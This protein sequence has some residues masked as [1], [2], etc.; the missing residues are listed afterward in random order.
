M[1]NVRTM[2]AWEISR[3]VERFVRSHGG[4]QYL[5]HQRVV[6]PLPE[7]TGVETCAEVIERLRRKGLDL[8][9]DHEGDRPH[10]FMN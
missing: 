4:S 10:L 3:D 8:S 9:M 7:K 2:S 6:C 5:K 1:G